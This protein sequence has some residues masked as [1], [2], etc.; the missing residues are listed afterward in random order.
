MINRQKSTSMQI[1][2]INQILSAEG[3]AAKFSLVKRALSGA[4]ARVMRG[5]MARTTT[6]ATTFMMTA[7]MTVVMTGAVIGRATP[8]QA[9]STAVPTKAIGL[10]NNGIPAS[11]LIYNGQPLDPDQAADLR[12]N[13]TDLSLLQPTPNDVW[14][15]TKLSATD[16]SAWQYPKDGQ[17]I[18]WKSL[19]PLN[20]E[21]WF[22]GQVVA[23]G[24]DGQLRQYRLVMGLNVHQSLM[25][26]A[27]LRKIGYPMQSPRWY[28]QLRI[29]FSD[30]T[31]RQRFIAELSVQGGLVDHK[32]W[33]LQE[34]E[35]KNE[36][37]VQD[38]MLEPAQITVPTAFAMGNLNATH[39][40]GRRILRAL[41]V[42]FV[43][44]DVPESVN[45]FSWEAGKI[46]SENLVLTH[47]YAEAFGETTIDDIRWMTFRIARLSRPDWQ[48]IVAAGN[49]PSDIAAV[50]LEKTIAR[51]NSLVALTEIQERL[52][53]AE[54]DL[55]YSTQTTLGS[56]Q[57]G[58]VTQEKYD[59]YALRF[60][61]GDPQS[62][63]TT[64]DIVR[65]LRIESMTSGIRQLTSMI[66]EKLQVFTMDQLLRDRSEQ[67][68]EQFI[69][70]I[71]QNP[72]KP[73]VQPLS[74]WGGPTGGLNI[75]ASRSIVTGSYFGS[76]S[77]DFRVSLVDQVTAGGRIGYF[78][79]V[80][81]IPKV[82]PGIGANLSVVRSYVH[83]RPVPSIQAADKKSWQDL[84]VPGF[85]RHLEGMLKVSGRS[86]GGVQTSLQASAPSA[87]PASS[88]EDSA[89]TQMQENLTK[90]LDELKENE[91]F[92]ITDSITLG[93][94]ASL[95][96]PLT[97]LLGID[98]V[99]FANNF[100][101]G[102]NANS[103][104]LR[105]TTFTRENGLIKIYLQNI[106]SQLTGV[107]FDFNLWLNIFRLSYDQKWGQ[108]Q[109]RAYHLNEK[110]SE[111]TQLRNTI[112]AMKGILAGN[113]S[114]LLENHFHPYQL[115]H[116]THSAIANGKFLWWRW[117]NIEES[118]RVRVRPPRDP[119][120]NF[121]P[122]DHERTLFSHRIMQRTGQNYHAFLG[123][124][125]DGVVQ[126]ST[127]W[128]PGIIT[129]GGGSN[130][131]DTFMG[132][133]R[134][135]MITTESEVTPSRPSPPVTT[136]TEHWAGWDL[137]KKDLF[138]TLDGIDSRV[139]SLG[140]KIP[141][142]DRNNFNDMRR[143][144]LY[145]I[146]STLIVYE[147]GME[148]LRDR[149]LV[150]DGRS[151]SWF[152]NLTGW[153]EFSSTDPEIINKI[154]IPM[155]GQARFRQACDQENRSG[156]N[157]DGSVYSGV[158]YRGQYYE[159]LLHWQRQ[160][161]ELRREYPSSREDQAKWATK[162]VTL[163]IRNVE[164]S[165]FIAAIGKENLYYQ[166]KISGFRT[167]DE[168][169]DT[170]DYTSS[171]IGTFNTASRAGIFRDFT[172]DYQIMASEMNASYLS[173]G[174]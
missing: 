38:A 139:S 79:G 50:I 36:I 93:A 126:N 57:L 68:R 48:E 170:A 123:D 163:L 47:K 96:I 90:F 152:Q 117:T 65:Y 137:A 103:V 81:G 140:L 12:S 141:L 5:A 156:N 144:Q 97:T 76:Q 8:A 155:M 66:N 62:P 11:D 4:T 119:A 91:S 29:K 168:N 84:W 71:R 53:K 39:L 51:R 128:R 135:S 15:N 122:A 98:A 169:G 165:Q 171:T 132:S 25:R 151:G 42:P 104:V 101:I 157:Q 55:P 143:L 162:V 72:F 83:V 131:R 172:A 33:V 145:E 31:S 111:E 41:L 7:L 58:K 110:P 138:K 124:V 125:L 40:Q 74:T 75:N 44:V 18:E 27:L 73:Y 80:D 45:M 32:R 20:P 116:R 173:E 108:A 159:C 59:G 1:R 28:R 107:S 70:H 120:R 35:T 115:D 174:F 109:T 89:Q 82:I 127:F 64:D 121:N 102:T 129:A 106:Q 26:S 92:T 52:P 19:V 49:Y 94:N 3:S 17:T 86:N 147:K 158:R 161:L 118:H 88:A 43:L 134:W 148:R 6:F 95:T 24:A 14:S 9:A 100:V 77:S 130:P 61:H 10:A 146:Q 13:G 154:L 99:S 46:I 56:V 60:T 21:G 142:I 22:R 167:R 30:S 34:S 153:N 164:L 149:L 87:P 112:L 37:L 150:Q 67:M 69:N 85:M 78:M 16:I 2:I 113:N 54:Q 133:A 105:R 23:V 136:V 114:E 166:L 160:L 63:L